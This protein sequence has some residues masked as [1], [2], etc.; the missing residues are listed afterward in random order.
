MSTPATLSP[1]TLAARTA[2]ERSSGV[3]LIALALPPRCRLERKSPLAPVRIIDA[4]TLP[5]ITK[6]R[7]SLPSAS[8]MNSCTRMLTFAPRNASITDL[9]DFSVSPSTTPM[10]CVPSSSL[11]TTGAPPTLLSTPSG[12]LG[13]RASIAIFIGGSS[14]V[15]FLWQA[16]RPFASAGDAK[17]APQRPAANQYGEVHGVAVGQG[18]VPFPAH[19]TK[20]HGRFDDIA[21]FDRSIRA[22]DAALLDSGRAILACRLATMRA[23]PEF[24]DQLAVDRQRLDAGCVDGGGRRPGVD[25]GLDPRQA[26]VGQVDAFDPADIDRLPVCFEGARR[27]GHRGAR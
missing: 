19:A 14:S 8:L 17:A 6:M 11:M 2:V 20:D 13:L 26:K 23:E 16:E 24:D 4:T 5:P 3:I 22:L 27:P 7:M 9:A 15:G 18:H 1:I 21:Q 12:C 25:L 10:P